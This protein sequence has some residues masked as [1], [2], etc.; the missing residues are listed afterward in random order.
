MFLKITLKEVCNEKDWVR[1]V[2]Y[3][4]YCSQTVAID[5]LLSLNFAIIFSFM[6]FLFR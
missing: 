5:V 1:N 4:K 2:A 6:Y 3:D